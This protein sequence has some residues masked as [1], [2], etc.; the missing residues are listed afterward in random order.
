MTLYTYKYTVVV[1]SNTEDKLDMYAH[2]GPSKNC[3][4]FTYCLASP[5]LVPV[6]CRPFS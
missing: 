4:Y 6:S 2:S 5:A 1:Y 3:A